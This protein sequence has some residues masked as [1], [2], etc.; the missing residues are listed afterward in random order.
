MQSGPVASPDRDAD[1]FSTVVRTL[2]IGSDGDEWTF[3][4]LFAC[5]TMAP[6]LVR[7]GRIRAIDLSLPSIMSVVG[8]G[9]H[10]EARGA[11]VGSYISSL[12]EEEREGLR[13]NA[14]IWASAILAAGMTR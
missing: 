11:D 12:S 13:R 10:M 7:D 9:A 8:H 14:R 2:S 3:D 1:F 4:D 5:I 6:R